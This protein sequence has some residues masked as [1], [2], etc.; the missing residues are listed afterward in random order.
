MQKTFTETLN[1]WYE[2]FSKMKV[3]QQIEIAVTGKRDPELFTDICKSFIDAGNND[4][5]FS[6]DWRFFRRTT[7]WI[8]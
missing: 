2:K 6:S 7:A 5:E 3:G 1:F 8:D 4:F